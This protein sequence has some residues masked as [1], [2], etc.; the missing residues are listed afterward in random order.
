[1]KV[2]SRCLFALARVTSF[3]AALS[4]F[5]QQ[6]KALP[7]KEPFH[8]TRIIVKFAAREKAA[9]QITFFQQQGLRIQ[10]Q[11]SL[12]PQVAVLD[13]ADANEAKAAKALAPAERSKRL[14]QRIAALRATGLFE[15][16]EPDYVRRLFAEPTDSAFV[17]GTLWA[18]KNTGQNGG[19]PGADI[20][21]VPAWDITTGSTNVI[22]AIVD[23]GIRYTH[24]DLVAQM[25]RDPAATNFVCGTNAVAGNSDPMDDSVDQDGNPE[26]HGTH[27]AGTIGAAAN[28]GF[29]HVG[30][31][32][33]VRLMACKFL[34]ERGGASSDAFVSDEIECLQFAQAHGARVINASFGGYYYSQSEFEAL[35]SLRD[36]GVLFVA[37][38]GNAPW[39]PERNNDVQPVYPASHQL[40]NVIAVA[41]TDRNDNL[42]DFSHYGRNSVHLGAPGVD[43]YSCVNSS[44]SAYDSWAG[45][46]MAAPHVAGAAALLLS[47]YPNATVAELRRRLLSGVVPLPSLTNSTVTGG[48]LN[49]SNSLLAVPTGSLAVEMFPHDGQNLSA[50]RLVMVEALITD[51]L[52][53]TNATVT[54]S[55]SGFTNLSLLDGGVAPDAIPGDG[56]YTVT[57]LVPTNLSTLQVVLQVS[58]PGWQGVSNLLTYLIVLPPA[59][60]NFANRTVIPQSLCPTTVT[61]SNLNASKEPGE[62]THA[63]P[64]DGRSV[65][66]SW[67]APFSGPVK[68]STAGSTLDTLLAV[69]TGST[70]TNLS[71]VASNDN[72]SYYDWYS[73]V[74]LW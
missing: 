29:P 39:L 65:W 41:A 54:A 21:A 6:N 50:G 36:H 14:Q 66:W 22:V 10:R 45:T 4:L 35:R 73:V 3:L 57:F 59:N 20:G 32:W 69:Y 71:L 58:A 62:P 7:D 43:I 70:V 44:D 40:Q 2:I 46:S 28:N 16:V 27:V 53:V 64:L 17:D 63:S 68:I 49:V 31:A 26:G 38:A 67:T 52:P 15:Y 47:R 72:A 30:V 34:N 12:L 56:I 51:L 60:D 5:A 11:F 25:W 9:G 74:R 13:L 61:G 18:L 19:T 42:A 1:M 55:I 8:P 24:Q 33:N 23:T 48:R 37:A